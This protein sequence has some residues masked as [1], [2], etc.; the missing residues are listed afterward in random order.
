VGFGG[1]GGFNSGAFNTEEFN[2]GPAVV[3]PPPPPPAVGTPFG[4]GPGSISYL[5]LRRA[6]QIRVGVI[7]APE[8]TADLLQEANNVVD[9]W[10]ALQERKYFIDDRYFLLTQN[11]PALPAPPS[12]TVGPTGTY[13][14]DV[15]GNPLTYR[16]QRII[17]ANLVLLSNTAT[18]TRI[19]IEIINV[20]DYADI[21]VLEVSTQVAIRM[22][23]QPTIPNVTIYCFPYPTPGNWLEL[24]MWPEFPKFASATSL[25]N[26]P[27]AYLELIIAELAWKAW[28]LRDKEAGTRNTEA[29]REAILYNQLIDARTVV[30][31]SNAPT[32]DLTP[33]LITEV[34]RG[35]SGA[36][37]N[38]LDGDFSQ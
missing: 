7:P 22:Y 32:P 28:L 4:P 34:G 30:A 24:F 38:Y 33:D 21:P 36:P 18:P 27:P 9:S 35:D 15:L 37:F 10:N 23:V 1:F 20:F 16:P 5:A 17:R 8:M 3:P 29:K 6:G 13:N 14:V 19:P 2:T 12:F 25:F 31:G 11:T 26:G